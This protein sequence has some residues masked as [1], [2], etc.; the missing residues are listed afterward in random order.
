M[1]KRAETKILPYKAEDMYRLVCDVERYP[2]FV[3]WCAAVRVESREK[4]ATGEIIIADLVASFK[5]F[6]EQ[7]RSK[8][9]CDETALTVNVDYLKGPFKTLINAWKFEPVP[10]GVKID[11]YVEFEFKSKIIEKVVGLVFDEAM[12]TV[13]GA[14][15]TR[16]YELF[17]DK[18]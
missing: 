2:E 16:A 18:E 12:R 4:T 11:F 17:H 15:E 9:T 6:R 13:M 3:P 14:F 8:V 1:T 7:F 10:E 5:V